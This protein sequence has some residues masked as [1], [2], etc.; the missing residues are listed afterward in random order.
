MFYFPVEDMDRT[1]DRV[2][3]RSGKAIGPMRLSTGDLAAACDDPQGGA[4]GL[5]QFTHHAS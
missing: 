3:A 4:F 2:R 5:Y 1:L